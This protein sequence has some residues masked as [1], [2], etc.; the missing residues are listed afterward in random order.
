MHFHTHT[1]VTLG[2]RR[3]LSTPDECGNAP[4]CF[5][6]RFSSDALNDRPVRKSLMLLLTSDFVGRSQHG[7]H[8]MGTAGF[9][10]H[11]DLKEGLT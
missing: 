8:A 11:S 7:I 3:M 6:S 10:V 9:K 1:A 4:Y 5:Y 2:F